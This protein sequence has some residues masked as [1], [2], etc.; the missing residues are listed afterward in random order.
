VNLQTTVLYACR[1][2]ADHDRTFVSEN[3]RELLGY[4]PVRWTEPGFWRR[5]LHPDDAP[6]VLAS[7]PLLREQGA[8]TIEYQLR[9]VAGSVVRVRDEMRLIC[10]SDTRPF[11]IVGTMIDA[12][13]REAH[14]VPAPGNGAEV[15]HDFSN[16][17]LVIA[18]HAHLLK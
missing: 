15:V 16:L 8:Q 1:P 17:L 4:E 10:D 12:S 14:L 3:V 7:M 5:A 2:S 11:E 6:R 9:R 18:G 13:A